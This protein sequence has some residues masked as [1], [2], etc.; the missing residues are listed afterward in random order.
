[1]PSEWWDVS[2]F[3]QRG[4]KGPAFVRNTDEGV[5]TEYHGVKLQQLGYQ[6]AQGYAIAKPMP[7]AMMFDWIH[8]WRSPASWQRKD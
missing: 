8:Q 3:P 5:E 6:L 4:D 1:M 7:A 2:T